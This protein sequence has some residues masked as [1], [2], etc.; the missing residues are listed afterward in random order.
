MNA[1]QCNDLDYECHHV[2]RYEKTSS[3]I[4]FSLDL[5]KEVIELKMNEW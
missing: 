2:F 3:R 4:L 1:V 5:N